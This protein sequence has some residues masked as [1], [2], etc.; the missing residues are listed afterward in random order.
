MTLTTIIENI[1]ML[2]REEM[3]EDKIHRDNWVEREYVYIDQILH[4]ARRELLGD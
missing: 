2:A 4:R 3:T 1:Q